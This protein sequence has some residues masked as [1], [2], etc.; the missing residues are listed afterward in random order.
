M[1]K[2]LTIPILAIA[3]LL[4]GITLAQSAAQLELARQVVSLQQGAEQKALWNNMANA[5]AGVALDKWG[6][7][8]IRDVRE[9]RRADVS[10]KLDAE[11]EKLYDDVY[12]LLE[13]TSPQ[14]ENEEVAN[15]YAK[16]FTEEELKALVEWLKSPLYQKYKE[17]APQTAE[18]YLNALMERTH[19]KVQDMQ[20]NFD[21]KAATIINA[22]K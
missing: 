8:L 6:D 22:A 16:N 4:P 20:G 3:L 11:L 21:K 12:K 7:R 18:V 10:K 1:K 19:I 15:F 2:W 9:N 14:I 5:A 17:I 13:T